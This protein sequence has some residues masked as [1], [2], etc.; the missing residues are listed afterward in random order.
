MWK[1]HL[2][3][4]VEIGA[5]DLTA[6]GSLVE[7]WRKRWAAD[8]GKVVV[9][10]AAGSQLSAAEL[11]AR[12]AE[13]AGRFA[14]AGV[15]RGD[16]VVLSAQASLDHVVAYVGLLRLGA[17]VLPLNTA[18]REPEVARAVVDAGATAAVTDEPGRA[19]WVIGAVPDAVVTPPDLSGLPGTAAEA[20]FDLDA[21]AGDDPALLVYTSGTTGAPKGAVLSHANLLASAEAVRL[22]WRWSPEDRLVLALPLFHMHGLGV[23]LH[24]TLTTGATALLL[25]RFDA[26]AVLAAIEDGGTMFFG[27]PTMW[28][29]LA[30]APGAETLARLRLGV[31][32]SAPLPPDLHSAVGQLAGTPPLERYGMTETVMLVSNP[33]EGER[34][35][36]SVGFP[37]PGVEVRLAG[38]TGEIEVRGPNV[39][40]GY[41]QRPKATAEAFRD[42][43]FRTGDLGEQDPDSYLRI[44]GRAKELI[45]SG[46]YN[47]YPR[48][49]E[50][51]LRAHP[52]VADAAVVGAP[53]PEWGEQVCAFVV[54]VDDVADDELAAWCVERL[55]PYKHPRRW[56]AL[57]EIPR[58]ALGKIQRT[59]L[60][61]RL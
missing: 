16:R 12:S 34:R 35:A 57:D 25:E 9:E 42:D 22:A 49:I 32:G 47:V 51:V 33:Y 31:S 40:A 21:V 56:H 52:A 39:F 8:P 48:E 23:G 50:E 20:K 2:P 60:T 37:L 17:L 26:M 6:G 10:D 7:V 18:Y 29:R 4:G 41:W 11:E 44:V 36:G 55:A 13:A 19:G 59:A 5:V 28:H 27:V 38:D 46:G 54:R 3:P 30:A 45:I 58:N 14:A 15:G 53:D 24:G 1:E 43:W 61:N